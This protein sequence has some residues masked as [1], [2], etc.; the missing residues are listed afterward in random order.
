MLQ[1]SVPDFMFH[2]LFYTL[3]MMGLRFRE[4]ASVIYKIVLFKD[5]SDEKIGA[6]DNFQLIRLSCILSHIHS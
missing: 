5:Y 4:S 1:S 2:V 6:Q 3:T